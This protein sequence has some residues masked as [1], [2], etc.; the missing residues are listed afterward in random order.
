MISNIN[1]NCE[2]FSDILILE[3]TSHAVSSVDTKY[4]LI[5]VYQIQEFTTTDFSDD[6]GA[7]TMCCMS[8]LMLV[9]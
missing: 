7:V 2:I 1:N 8:K 5:K 6:F 3:S 9:Q 4:K